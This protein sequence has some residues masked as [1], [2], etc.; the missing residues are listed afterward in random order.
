MAQSRPRAKRYYWNDDPPFSSVEIV[1]KA[2]RETHS[3]EVRANDFVSVR[4]AAELL[5]PPRLSAEMVEHRRALGFPDLPARPNVTIRSVDSW[6]GAGKLRAQ[7]RG[8]ET[9]IRLRDLVQFALDEGLLEKPKYH[10]SG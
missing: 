2:G 4:E 9:V 10:L 3:R 1:W 7:K 5:K 6:V 8:G